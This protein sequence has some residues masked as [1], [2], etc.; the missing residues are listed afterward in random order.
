MLVG[1]GQVDDDLVA[2]PEHRQQAGVGCAVG[3]DSDELADVHVADQRPDLLQVLDGEVAGNVHD[4]HLTGVP[5]KY[6]SG[7]ENFVG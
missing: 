7:A 6:R 3:T 4:D 2:L 5:A 1:A